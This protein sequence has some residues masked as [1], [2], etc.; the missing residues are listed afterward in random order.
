MAV[1]GPLRYFSLDDQSLH[2]VTKT[3]E[4][5][6]EVMDAAA[7]VWTFGKAPLGPFKLYELPQLLLLGGVLNRFIACWLH[8]QAL[9]E[10]AALWLFQCCVHMAGHQP[11]T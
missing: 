8:S 6:S 3:K 9:I 4:N 5:N 11:D 2:L 1:W 7:H 10:M